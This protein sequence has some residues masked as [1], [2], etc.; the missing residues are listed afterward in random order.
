VTNEETMLN[1]A[2]VIEPEETTVNPDGSITVIATML[3]SDVAPE[4]VRCGL[5]VS[6]ES[7]VVR[8]SR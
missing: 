4:Y 8:C 1:I 5:Q 6:D 3:P 2:F 7:E